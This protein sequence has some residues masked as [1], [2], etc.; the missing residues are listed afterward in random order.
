[1]ILAHF[2]G[3]FKRLEGYTQNL[4]KKNMVK[5]DHRLQNMWKQRK[6]LSVANEFYSHINQRGALSAE[7]SDIFRHIVIFFPWP[8]RPHGPQFIA[9]IYSEKMLNLFRQ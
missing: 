1:M 3:T 8:H 2:S 7:I 6:Y 5:N 4:E 9:P